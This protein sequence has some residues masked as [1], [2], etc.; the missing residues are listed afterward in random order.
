M[1]RNILR[2]FP[3]RRSLSMDYTKLKELRRAQDQ[4]D[5]LMREVGIAN[6]HMNDH[7]ETCDIC[8]PL[9]NVQMAKG[10]GCQI[11][12]AL[13]LAHDSKMTDMKTRRFHA[14]R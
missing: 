11:G 4:K 14:R 1:A 5:R 6:S 9:T 12:A 3:E 2:M 13:S 7:R 8:R 10:V